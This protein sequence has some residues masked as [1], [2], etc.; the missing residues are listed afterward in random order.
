MK[1]VIYLIVVMS[2]LLF[3]KNVYG[4]NTATISVTV[5]L[6]ETVSISLD[7]NTWN[8]GSISLGTTVESSTFTVTNN[9]N[10][11]ED[12]SIKTTNGAGGWRIGTIPGENVFKVAADVEPYSSYDIVISTTETTLITDLTSGNSKSFKLQYN[13]PTSDTYGGGVDQSFTITLTA[14]KH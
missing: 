1:K 9:G 6:E 2:M 3:L 7:T 5:S 14:T 11:A 4:E 12:I 8:I 13:A 10:V